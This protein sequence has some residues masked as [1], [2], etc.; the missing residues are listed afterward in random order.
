MSDSSH[1]AVVSLS[2][3][4]ADASSL[5]RVP[6]NGITVESLEAR[7][8]PDSCLGLGRAD[9]GCAEVIRPGFLVVLG[10][11]FRYRTDM[12]GQV[13]LETNLI[14]RELRVEFRQVGGIGGWSSEFHADDATLSEADAVHIRH[15][16]DAA[17]FF[18]LP[19]EVSNGQPIPDL[20]DYTLTLSHG[21][22]N[23]TVHTYDGTGP[24]ESPAL[25]EFINWLKARA[26]QPGPV[27][28]TN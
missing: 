11:G 12:Q 26:P 18:E 1:P 9:E 3:A 22:R 24:H 20:F 21:R 8:W 27:I 4:I 19:E 13:R 23:H 2:A 10:D 6:I 17:N 25:A 15:F 7:E 28:E 5:L 16:I 14:D